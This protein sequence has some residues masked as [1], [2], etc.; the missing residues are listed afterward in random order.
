MDPRLFQVEGELLEWDDYAKPFFPSYT[1]YVEDEDIARL[2][3]QGFR[4]PVALER[5]VLVLKTDNSGDLERALRLV[6]VV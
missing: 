1:V 4:N 3:A 6:E 5:R 2:E